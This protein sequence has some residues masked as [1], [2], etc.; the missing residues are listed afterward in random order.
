[1][2]GLWQP[3]GLAQLQERKELAQRS[4]ERCPLRR[5]QQSVLDVHVH[6]QA[7]ARVLVRH[8][9]ARVVVLI[10]LLI[11]G[12]EIRQQSHLISRAARQ[13]HT[14]R[15]VTVRGS[16]VQATCIANDGVQTAA[17]G[18]IVKELGAGVEVLTS[19]RDVAS[20]QY[21]S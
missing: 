15:A 4:L 18:N 5:L 6:A 20:A 2:T 21:P 3:G 19:C 9:V 1:M 14:T 10:E 7:A 13:E 12:L 16:S 11:E 17:S 8:C